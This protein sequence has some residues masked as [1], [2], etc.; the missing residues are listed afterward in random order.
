MKKIIQFN[1]FFV[2]L[3]QNSIVMRL[4]KGDH[5]DYKGDIKKIEKRL[6]SKE[7]NVIIDTSTDIN[8]VNNKS[9]NI[10]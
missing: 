8:K 1:Y 4:F 3:N 5:D 9:D 7:E 2:A 10:S 6:I